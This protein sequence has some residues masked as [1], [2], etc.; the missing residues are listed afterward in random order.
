M[1]FHNM[2]ER[3]WRGRQDA[4]AWDQLLVWKMQAITLTLC[5]N[6]VGED[7]DQRFG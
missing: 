1:T 7:E 4:I 3:S 5:T 6:V 2:M